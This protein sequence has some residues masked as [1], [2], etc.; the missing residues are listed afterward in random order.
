MHITYR[1]LLWIYIFILKFNKL[2]W[3]VK[4]VLN[5]K[6][7]FGTKFYIFKSITIFYIDRKSLNLKFWKHPGAIIF[8]LFKK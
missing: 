4:Y 3:T 7:Y 8:Y 1:P 5:M 6:I 2:I